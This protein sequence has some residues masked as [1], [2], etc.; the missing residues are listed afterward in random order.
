MAADAIS[1]MRTISASPN[2]FLRIG[3]N[4]CTEADRYQ[5]CN[6]ND[7]YKMEFYFFLHVH[8][9]HFAH[10]RTSGPGDFK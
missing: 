2:K 5:P 4:L 10:A 9:K 1:G 8:G 3:R 6:H 7:N